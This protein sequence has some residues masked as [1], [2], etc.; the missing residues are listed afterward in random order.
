MFSVIVPV[1][2]AE[3]TLR[4][5]LDSLL[6]QT[7]KDFE[8]I[9][10]DDQSIDGTATV[11]RS[12]DCRLIQLSER[13]G[14]A[15]CRN[16]AMRYARGAILAFTDSDCRVDDSWLSNIQR[17]FS[18]NEADALMGRLILMPSTILGDSISALGF[19]AGGTLGFDRIWKVDPAGYTDSLSSCN[20]AVKREVFEGIGGFDE[21]FPY[22]G[23]EDSLFAYHL[24]RR[25]FKIRYCPD[26]RVH[27]RARDSLRDFLRWQFK[28]GVSSYLFSRKVSNRKDFCSLRMWSTKNVVLHCLTDG[29]GP[30]ILCLLGVSLI[31]QI[32]G[33]LH[34]ARNRGLYAGA[35]H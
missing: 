23:G 20:C 6:N 28:R 14:P 35:D 13:H 16:L 27:H 4:D 7:Y 9:V 3:S 10:V 5:L 22:P 30:L 21:T 11:A 31:F 33:F 1:R 34:A 18:R 25:N 29:K 19:P 32:M 2:N 12:Y 17:H 24:R 8:V 15:F 26:V